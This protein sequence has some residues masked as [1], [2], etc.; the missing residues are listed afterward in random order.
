VKDL[1]SMPARLAAFLR[2]HDGRGATVD[3][4]EL[5]TGGY[6]RVMARASV[7][8]DDG[9]EQVLVLRGDPAAG[10]AMLDTDRDEE[11]AVLQALT[12]LDRVPMPAARWYDADG[13]HLGTKCI[14][15]DCAEGASL[16]SVIS[17]LDD[18]TIHRDA[19]VDAMATVHAVPVDS[20]PP[21][22]PR[23]TSW[24]AYLD[25][26]NALWADAERE[27]AESNP[28][29]R[30]VRAWL[31]GN[32]PP[33]MALTLCHG[34]FQASNLLLDPEVGLQVIDWEYAHI[35]DPRED[36]G[37][38]SLYSMSSPPSLYDPDPE[39]FLA[40]YRER[41]GTDEVH[42]NQATVGYFAVVSAVRIF[43]GILNGARAMY[44]GTGASVI[45]AYNLN[46]A[47]IGHRNFLAA[48]AGLAEPLAALRAA[49]TE[50]FA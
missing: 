23:P 10:E 32:R 36:L 6:S 38:Y 14:V 33:P 16:F 12:E 22:M 43:I 2:Q 35:G 7:R 45:T 26:T 42:V 41:T 27:L 49:T 46:A 18:P 40:R 9:S 21:S 15:L 3:R 5:M 50:V 20:L 39:A 1:S 37:W 44:D 34:D 48:C 30:Y 11:W 19:F 31:D 13:T 25:A 17:G 28:T 47:G 29:M 4:Y 8:W 24:D